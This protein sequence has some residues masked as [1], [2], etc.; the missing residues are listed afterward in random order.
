MTHPATKDFFGHNPQG[1][2]RR[3]CRTCMSKNTKKHSKANPD[4]VQRRVNKRKKL[5]SKNKNYSSKEMRDFLH[6][7]QSQQCFYCKKAIS[8]ENC[9]LDHKTPLSKGGLDIDDNL[10]LSC[11]FCNKEKHNKTIEEYRL[12]K[13]RNGEIALF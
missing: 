6:E 9:D 10:V 7:L 8:I 3:V 2:F 4:I 12:W 11:S 13:T 1:G 5:E